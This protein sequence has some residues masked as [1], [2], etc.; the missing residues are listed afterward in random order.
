MIADLDNFASFFY[1]ED[2]SLT[3]VIS[4]LTK[5]RKKMKLSVLFKSL[6]SILE[7]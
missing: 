4:E 6:N 2:L 5:E 7:F 3:K 1:C